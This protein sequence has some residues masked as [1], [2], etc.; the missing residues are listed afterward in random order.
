[1]KKFLFLF[2]IFSFTSILSFGQTKQVKGKVTD[3]SGQGLPGI[4]IIEKGT[5][6]G[7]ISNVAGTY[8]ISVSSDTSI[9]VFSF[10]GMITQELSTSGRTNLDVSMKQSTIG[11]DEVIV[12]GFGSQKKADVTGATSFVEMENMIADRPIVNAA[13]ALQGISAGLKVVS[14]SGQPGKTGT[15]INIRGFTS[16]NGGGPLVLVDNVPMSLDDVNPRD[17]ESVTVLK[18]AAASS[19]YGSRAA[20]GVVLITTKKAEKNQPMKFSFSTTQSFSTPSELPQAATTRQF[21]EALD[22]FGVYRYFSNQEVDTWLNYLDQYDSD[23]SQLEF[24]MDPV[25]NTAYP[26]VLDEGTGIY[27]PLSESGLIN[28]FLNNSGVSTIQNFTMSGGAEKVSYRVNFGHSYEDG[29]LVTDNDKFK[30]YNL[31]AYLNADLTSNLKSTTNLFYRASERTNP[32]GSY[33]SAIQRTMYD[34]I[35]H[36]ELP[37]GEVLPFESPGNLERYRVPSTKTIDNFR[38]FQSLE[39]SPFKDLS[40]TAEYTF[41]KGFTTTRAIDNQFEF[42]SAHKFIKLEKDSENTKYTRTYADFINHASNIYATYKK[43]ISNHNFKI[44][45]GYNIET[46]ISESFSVSRKNM[47]SITT[48]GIDTGIGEYDGSDSYGDWA[49]MGYFT[50]FNYNYKEKY[51]FEANGRYDGS[52]RF[53]EGSRFGFFPSFSAGWNIGRETFM[54]S[55]EQVSNLKLRGSWGEIGNQNTG[56]LYPTIP[57]YKT[58]EVRW[59]DLNTDLRYVSINPAQLVSPWLTWEVVQTANI[60]LDAGFFK[61]KLGISMDMYTRKTFDMLI[62]GAELPAILGTEAPFANAADLETKGWEMELSWQDIK[63]DFNYEIQFNL[64]DNQT[65]ITK[66]DNPAGL[67]SQYYVGRMIGEIWG[68]VTDGYYTLD[69]FV[70]GT[71][72]AH[73]SGLERQLKEGVVRIE[74]EPIPYPGDVKYKDLNGD[75][76]I[77][78]GNSTLYPEYDE[79]TGELIVHTGPG[80][81]QIIGNSVAR[82]Q[83]G[84]NTFANYKNFD[85]TLMLYG[86]AKRDLNLGGDLIWPYLSQFDHIFAHQMDYWTPDNQDAYYPRIYGN[87]TDNSG[88]NYGL[89]TRTQTKYLSDGAYLRIK[90]ITLGYTLPKRIL[91]KVK[92]STLRVFVSGNNLFTFDNLPVGLDPDQTTNGVYPIMRNYSVGL[93]LTF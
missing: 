46:R 53:A 72:D 22:D 50:R 29:V 57:G 66:F 77:N 69:D 31:N 14:T 2:W 6:N 36:F 34:P 16:I 52:S 56:D 5:A 85:F 23:P 68:Y 26:M 58:P 19:I 35:G 63:G 18:D 75:G 25:S 21:V 17:I 81:K 78:N 60:G 83:F 3:E 79:T 61:N 48:P 40:F 51:L 4:T 93:N 45:G 74:D 43:S 59:I 13:E 55:V 80:D 71:L 89:S 41:Q 86:V 92:I 1:M 84:I 65:M 37:D 47:I 30:N 82:Y 88:S 73:L 12:V 90:N 70:E 38:F 49:V 91:D 42:A 64:T 44:L 54:E 8:E 32:I 15:S 7:T 39:Y 24:V 11:L 87:P 20:F 28:D 62:P 10:I 76:T 33:S 27:Y 9:L 67:L